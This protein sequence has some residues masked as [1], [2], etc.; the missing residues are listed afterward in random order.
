METVT[1]HKAKSELSKLLAR[2]EAGEEIIIA[3]GNQ[4]IAIL[5]PIKALHGQ[6]RVAGRWRNKFSV[7]VSAFEALPDDELAAFEGQS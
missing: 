7:P 1:T 5:A 6:P 3:R 2:V 4:P